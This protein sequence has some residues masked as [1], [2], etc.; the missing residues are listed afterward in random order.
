MWVGTCW[1]VELLYLLGNRAADFSVGRY[2]LLWK[3]R[4]GRICKLVYSGKFGER[5]SRWTVCR[6]ALNKLTSLPSSSSFSLLISETLRP[7]PRL[8]HLNEWELLSL[9][10]LLCS[11]PISRSRPASF[12]CIPKVASISA[13]AIMACLSWEELSHLYRVQ[14]LP[15]TVWE[16]EVRS[17]AANWRQ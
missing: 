6:E 9:L 8:F 16:M 14:L 1:S 17:H 10:V 3:N 12:V 13:C 11:V 2:L 5:W 4:I 15:F 7:P